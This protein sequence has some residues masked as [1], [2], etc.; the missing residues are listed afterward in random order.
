MSR[1]IGV[2]SQ[3]T[4]FQPPYQGPY[5][6]LKTDEKT[7][8]V[9]TDNKQK[10][11]SMDRL[12]PAFILD[13]T[14]PLQHIVGGKRKDKQDRAR[15][16]SRARIQKSTLVLAE[17]FCSD[18]YIRTSGFGYENTNQQVISMLLSEK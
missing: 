15:Y 8:V 9:E 4:G 6:V 12:K 7:Y 14:P 2:V 11:V 10:T 17:N 1:H 16:V 18:V 3:R 5:R 13:D